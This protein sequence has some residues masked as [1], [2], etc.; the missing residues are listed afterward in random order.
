MRGI[1]RL[2]GSELTALLMK[3]WKGVLDIPLVEVQYESLVADLYG[4]VRRLLDFCGLDFDERCIRCG[5]S[6]PTVLTLSSDQVRQLIYASSVGRHAAWGDRLAD[7]QRGLTATT[8][9]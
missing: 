8:S 3:Y 6:D 4:G 5:Q 1:T 9:P 7:L 2:G